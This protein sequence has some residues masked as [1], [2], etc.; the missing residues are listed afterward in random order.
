MA[1]LPILG[2]IL[3]N[4]ILAAA[5]HILSAHGFYVD[6]GNNIYFYGLSSVKENDPPYY[7]TVRT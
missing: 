2:D 4:I 5:V 6:D 3:K 1:F 7:N